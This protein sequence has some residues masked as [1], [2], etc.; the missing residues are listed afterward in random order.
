MIIT[1]VRHT[2]VDVAPGTCYGQSD[3]PLKQSFNEEAE[4][5]RKKLIKKVKSPLKVYTS[6]LSRC[7][8]LA[9]YCGFPDAIRD[10]RL[11]ELNFGEWE[12]QRYESIKDPR[13]QEWFD[14]W[15]ETPAT[16]GESLRDQL[17]RVRNFIDEI[18]GQDDGNVIVFTHGGVIALARYIAGLS[19]KGTLFSAQPG[20]GEVI[21]LEITEQGRP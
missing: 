14:N 9:E 11:M 16:G 17:E 20:Y 4:I 12:M 6:P 3:V 2:S 15:F 1:F 8:R 21:T 13:L 7:T 18:C 10:A 5:V 19:D